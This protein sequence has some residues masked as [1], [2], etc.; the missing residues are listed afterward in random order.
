LFSDI[1]QT[2]MIVSGAGGKPAGGRFH[3]G[4]ILFIDADPAGGEVA[5]FN[6]R[7]VGYEVTATEDEHGR[8]T[9]LQRPPSTS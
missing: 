2:I 5:L 8:L 3:A 6:L 7:K 1:P 4:R 9:A